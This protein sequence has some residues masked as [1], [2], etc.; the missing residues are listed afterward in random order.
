MGALVGGKRVKNTSYGRLF[1]VSVGL[2]A[3]ISGGASIAQDSWTPEYVDGKLQPLPDG[4]PNQA[5]SLVVL[6]EP[7]SSDGVYARDMQSALRDVSPVP[8]EVIDRG[9]VGTYPTWEA[10]GWTLDQPQ[11]DQGY[12]PIVYVL[13]GSILDLLT[14]PIERDL[15]VTM[16]DLNFINVTEVTPYV[17]T[18][19]KDAPWGNSFEKLVEYAKANP[20]TVK[21]LSRSPGSGGYT[22]MERYMELQ[23]IEFDKRVGGSH[24]EI[25][26]AIGAGV[27]DVGITQV[28]T[29]LTHWEAGKI[30][31][32]MVT[33]DQRAGAPWE[34]VPSAADMGM[35]G[36]PWA[37][38]RGFALA[39]AVPDQHREWLF[40]LFRAGAETEDF[41]AARQ[42]LPGNALVM[43]NHDETRAMADKAKQIAEPVIRK[44][45]IHWDQQ[46]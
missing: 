44:L 39:G 38:N 19:R 37:Q 10:L 4:F 8:I 21:Y 16:D 36:E 2:A 9:E 18:S 31:I 6:D 24:N 34:D 25:Q 27:A 1:A 43:M 29:A 11:G 14:V 35:A 7:G 20:G 22:A 26:S 33:G 41:K 46:K 12:Y 45:G 13:P 28:E 40:E 30:E 32:L 42:R 17:V 15:N 23:G 5:I 3:L